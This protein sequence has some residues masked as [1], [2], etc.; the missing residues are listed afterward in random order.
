[1]IDQ[2]EAAPHA[3]C[4]PSPSWGEGD[5]N[6]K[7]YSPLPGSLR[8]PT[9]PTELGFTRVRQPNRGRSR[10][11]PTSTGRGEESSWRFN[12]EETCSSVTSDLDSAPIPY[13]PGVDFGR[14]LDARHEAVFIG[15]MCQCQFT[16]TYNRGWR[17]THRRGQDRCIGEVRR[18]FD[19]AA[20]T[21][22]LVRDTEN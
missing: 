21:G 20:E 15:L 17:R 11:H 10:K 4:A 3:R 6:S 1:M 9:S 2:F 16:G 13:H 8:D 19:L 18:G 12:L 7:V 5:S 14:L 22:S